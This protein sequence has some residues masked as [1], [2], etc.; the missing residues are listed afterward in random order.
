MG[1]WEKIPDRPKS[2]KFRCSKCG[3]TCTCIKYE[4]NRTV[5]DYKYCPY[6]REPMESEGVGMTREEAIEELNTYDMSEDNEDTEF[7]DAIALAI[8]ALEQEPCEDAV[9]RANLLKMYE[10]RFIELQ[11]AHRT[12]TQSGVNW[13]INTLKDMPPVAPTQNWIPVSERLPEENGFYLATCDGEICGENEHFTGLA[14]YENGKWVD[15][16]E[17]YQC[18]L[19]WMPLP[20]PYKGE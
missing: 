4:G 10:D 15:D 14:E 11:K 7:K 12:D 18:V 13:C 16:E 3:R 2:Q 6:C 20:E 1:Y 5:C 17:D 9:S 19:A 8:K